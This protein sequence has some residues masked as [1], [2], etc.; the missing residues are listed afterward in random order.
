MQVVAIETVMY[1]IDIF[2]YP[3]GNFNIISL[4]HIKK[5][6]SNAFVGDTGHLDSRSTW[7]A[8]RAW[9][10]KVNNNKPQKIVSFFPQRPGVF[11]L[12]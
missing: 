4:V 2:V 5:W 11:V 9:D 3:T 8:Q 6:K 1:E 10:M 12:A 7:L